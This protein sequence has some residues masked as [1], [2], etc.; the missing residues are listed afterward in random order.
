MGTAQDLALDETSGTLVIGVF[1]RSCHLGDRI[2]SGLALA[3]DIQFLTRLPRRDIPIL[4]ANREIVE[5]VAESDLDGDFFRHH[6]PPF[7]E[8][9]STASMTF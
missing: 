3:H 5:L 8:A 7:R 4:E 2:E 6:F 9:Y 1:C